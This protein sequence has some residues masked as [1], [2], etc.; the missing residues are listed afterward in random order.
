MAHILI[1]GKAFS[2]IKRYLVDHGHSYTVLQDVL[3]TKYPD[4]RFKS[5]V[6]A[7]FSHID[8]ML[9]TVDKINKK[10]HIDASLA[11]YEQYIVTNARVARHLGL[12]GLSL[13]SAHA[14]TDKEL[15]R[16]KFL[17]APEKISPGFSVVETIED[18]T[19]FAEQHTFPLILKPANL[20]KSL[21]VTKSNS[22]EEL[23]ANYSNTLEKIEA[24]YRKYAPGVTPKLLIEE[25]LEGHIHSVDAFVDA[26]GTP[27]VLANVVDY[28]TGYDIGY[29]DN[30]HYSR[31]LPSA[32]PTHEIDDIRRVAAIGCKSLG[33]TSSPAHV[34]IIVTAE[35]PR[36]VEIGARNGGYRDRMHELANDIDITQNALNLALNKPLSIEAKKNSS[37][38]VFELFPRTPGTFVEVAHEQ[39][40]KELESFRYLSM[41]AK[42]GT[43]VGKAGDG[44][45]MCAVAILANDDNKVFDSDASF[46]Q[47]NVVVITD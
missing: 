26:D 23:L 41:K 34:E 14:C 19:S 29:D 28:Q 24:V 1:I 40:L 9:Q 18:V 44:F 20:S 31:L 36:I 12:P 30:F 2:G 4:K 42:P 7:D 15:M 10:T 22:I 27:H 38:G 3:A 13:E 33:M 25:F 43:F 32:L 16:D 5:R 39:E 45:K 17:Q 11:M 21:L 35:G 37:V 46:L 6:V 47:K 8:Q